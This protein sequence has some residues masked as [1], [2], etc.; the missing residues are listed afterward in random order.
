MNTDFQ[1]ISGRVNI[2]KI[3]SRG[4]NLITIFFIDPVSFL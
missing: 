2:Y 3:P 1:F 4:T